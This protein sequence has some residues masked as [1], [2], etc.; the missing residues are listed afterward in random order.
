VTKQADTV[1]NAPY[2]ATFELDGVSCWPSEPDWDQLVNGERL[3]GAGIDFEAGGVDVERAATR[4][5]RR[6]EDFDEVV[7]AIHVAALPS[8]CSQLVADEGNPRFAKML[9]DTRTVM[10]QGVQLWATKSVD[11]LGWPYGGAVA[12]AYVEPLDTYCDMSVQLPREKWDPSLNIRSVAY[13]CGILEEQTGDD[14]ATLAARVRSTAIKYMNESS[15]SQWPNATTPSHEF[16]WSLLY[17]PM[18][19]SGSERIDAQFLRANTVA[20]ERYVQTPPG[21]HR[22]RLRAN[23][24]GYPNLFLAG[25]WVRNGI[26]VGAVEGA[27]TAALWA[28]QAICGSPT[29]VGWEEF[30]L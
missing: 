21:F 14:E 23:E 6:G 16:D 9:R 7:L 10:T 15:L 19:R 24:S 8:I 26:D 22:S 13:Y 18:N 5:L 25:D 28:S 4:S 27:V 3:R 2:R 12:S 20:T 11:E 1:G 30:L 29:S 17:D